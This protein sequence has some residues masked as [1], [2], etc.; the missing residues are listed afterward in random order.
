MDKTREI[1]W[2]K[3]ADSETNY[4]FIKAKNS[5]NKKELKELFNNKSFSWYLVEKNI[6][7]IASQPDLKLDFVSQDN[8]DIDP[9][10][11]NPSGENIFFSAQKPEFL[12]DILAQV[13]DKA[14]SVGEKLWWQIDTEDN[15][16]QI[17]IYQLRTEHEADQIANALT[18]G[19]LKIISKPRLLLFGE[20]LNTD[21]IKFLKENILSI[22]NSQ[23]PH[24]KF[25]ENFWQN[26]ALHSFYFFDQDGDW[27]LSKKDDWY[28]ALSSLSSEFS[29]VTKTRSLP[30]GTLYTELL[31]N[32]ETKI[33]KLS[34]QDK[35]YW[36][37][38]DFYGVDIAEQ[39]Y[40]SNSENLVK[41]LLSNSADFAEQFQNC[42]INEDEKLTNLIFLD[43]I[44]SS[45]LKLG[46][47][48]AE[49]DKF[50]LLFEYQGSQTQGIRLCWQ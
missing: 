27:F 48:L 47:F 3:I 30:D 33:E 34:W 40:L 6:L 7:A 19:D 37:M 14:F 46:D 25:G 5:F 18:W 21:N 2:F 35:A 22:V 32:K 12:T 1:I 36:Q 50:V 41:D 44:A 45:Q 8:P 26:N 42:A 10:F 16:K 20:N 28:P 39:N 43:K 9:H 15:L 49:V 23:A 13:G 29:I 31:K 38:Q 4:Y 24:L 11:F 17:N